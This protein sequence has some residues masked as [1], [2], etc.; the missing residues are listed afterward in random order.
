MQV[1]AWNQDP[2]QLV[3]GGQT[4]TPWWEE[5]GEEEEGLPGWSHEGP[6]VVSSLRQLPDCL[7][8]PAMLACEAWLLRSTD[9]R[10]VST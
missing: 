1:T 9:P 4:Q 7:G 10:A 2:A 6:R 3:L 5:E 8:P